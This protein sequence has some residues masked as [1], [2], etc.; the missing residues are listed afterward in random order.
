MNNDHVVRSVDGS[1]D[2]QASVNSFTQELTKLASQ[3]SALTSEIES[4]VNAFFETRGVNILPKDMLVDGVVNLLSNDPLRYNQL[5]R[6]VSRFVKT[7]VAAGKLY[8]VKGKGGGI[9]R[10]PPTR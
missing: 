5:S 4:G 2:V 3:E 1:I 6:E 8:P 9:S 7:S 10:V